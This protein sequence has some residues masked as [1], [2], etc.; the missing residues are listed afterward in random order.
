MAAISCPNCGYKQLGGTKCQKCSTLFAYHET[1]G[2]P[3]VS[4]VPAS[5]FAV[6]QASPGVFRRVYRVARWAC[7]ALLVMVM[8]LLLRQAPSPQIPYDPEAKLRLDAKLT[9]LEAGARAG[10]PHQLRLDAAELNSF[11]GDN[12]ALKQGNDQATAP[13]LAQPAPPA[14]SASGAPETASSV[15]SLEEVQSTVRDV[16]ITMRDDRVQAYVLFDFHGKDL[17]LTL[18]G[19]L[20]VAGGYLR[21]E[22]V[23]GKLGSLPLWQSTL[24][25]A[26][27][28]MLDS[29]D[30]R[31]KFRVPPE[32]A[33]IRI[34][35]GELVVA[36]R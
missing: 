33:D 25:N 11:L 3:E 35:N 5:S 26:V 36:Y 19:R 15:P 31:E 24:E 6:H 27:R 30:N 4:S 23:S 21:F 22:P 28:R 13:P 2:N 1:T 18:E 17:S 10:Q 9:A 14:A 8:I 16:K 32:I 34:D 7:L 20:R 12:L 29:P